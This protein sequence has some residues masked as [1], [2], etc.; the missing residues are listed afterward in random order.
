LGVETTLSVET[1]AVESLLTTGTTA[2]D[3][4]KTL[5]APLRARAEAE[6]RLVQIPFDSDDGGMQCL[7]AIACALDA[8]ND[9]GSV[10]RVAVE[11]SPEQEFSTTGLTR[12]LVALRALLRPRRAVGVITLPPRLS[13]PQSPAASVPE[14]ITTLAHCA[15][16]TITLAGFGTNPLAAA[17]APAHGLLTPHSLPARGHVLAPALRHST[18]L[19][20]AGGSEQNLGFR[21]KRRKWVVETVHLGIEGGSGER[22]TEP[23]RKV[24]HE[25]APVGVAI[26]GAAEGVE[27]VERVEP[28][29]A[30]VEA[31][32]SE[33]KVKVKEKKPR[34]KV[35]FGDDIEVSHDSGHQH[36]DGCGHGRGKKAAPKVEIRHDRPELYEF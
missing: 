32:M 20:V 16:A 1:V 3:A 4:S 6:G 8:A 25:A 29:R 23:V 34:A 36:H 13:A 19:G 5:P 7:S 17:Y 11:I 9:S 18:L 30:R 28:A 35:R 24:V 15:D 31:D 12:F 2:L 21:L 33:A 27:G 10:A 26:E 14:W 22:R